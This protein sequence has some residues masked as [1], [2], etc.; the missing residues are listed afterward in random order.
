VFHTYFSQYGPICENDEFN[1]GLHRPRRISVLR[2][3]DQIENLS[4]FYKME[5]SLYNKTLLLAD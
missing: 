5:M 4:I 2:T 1:F 3:E